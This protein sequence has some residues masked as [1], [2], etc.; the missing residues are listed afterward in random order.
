MRTWLKE[1]RDLNKLTHEEIA[2]KCGISRA[3]YTQI[4]N[5]NRRPS[6]ETAKAIANILGFDWTM[7]FE[8]QEKHSA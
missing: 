6:V 2:N 8:K 7:F 4:E 3:F 1:A 5:G